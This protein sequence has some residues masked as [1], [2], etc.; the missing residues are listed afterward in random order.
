M[1]TNFTPLPERINQKA[2]E[3]FALL[4]SDHVTDKQ[5]Q[6][7]DEWMAESDNHLEAYRQISEVLGRP[8]NFEQYL[9]SAEAEAFCKSSRNPQ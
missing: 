2:S 6:Q 9:R 8:R 1:S 4:Q 5:Q 3:W 7:F